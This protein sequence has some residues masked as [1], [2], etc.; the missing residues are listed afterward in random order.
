MNADREQVQ[1]DKQSLC[2]LVRAIR[3]LVAMAIR[4]GANGRLE[5]SFTTPFGVKYEITA[6]PVATHAPITKPTPILFSKN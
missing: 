4:F 3:V 6:T 1:M 5:T 2:E